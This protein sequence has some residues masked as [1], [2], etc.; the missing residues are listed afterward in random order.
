[1]C[2]LGRFENARFSDKNYAQQIKLCNSY[3]NT[4]LKLPKSHE[5]IRFNKMCRIKQPKP[6]HINITL[7]RYR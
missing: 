2:E 1:M 7:F 6:N 5:A 4:E 3:K